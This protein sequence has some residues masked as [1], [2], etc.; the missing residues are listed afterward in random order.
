VIR[1]GR[2]SRQP[3]RVREYKQKNQHRCSKVYRGSVRLPCWFELR[4]PA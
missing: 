2:C 1:F 3:C 4:K